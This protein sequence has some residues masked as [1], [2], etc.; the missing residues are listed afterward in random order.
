MTTIEMFQ[1]LSDDQMK[2]LNSKLNKRFVRQIIT[3]VVLG[4]AAV[5]ATSLIINKLKTEDEAIASTE[6]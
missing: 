1:N 5:V 6:E 3:N 4:A 2:A